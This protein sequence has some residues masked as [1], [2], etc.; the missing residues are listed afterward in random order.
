MKKDHTERKVLGL[1]A[2]WLGVAAAVSGSI[3]LAACDIDQTEEGEMP[4]V[5][6]EGGKLPEYEVHTPD[7]DVD[8]EEKTIKVPDV[9]IDIPEEEENEPPAKEEPPLPDEGAN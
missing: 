2:R 9:D 7:V 8:M 5:D 6:V 4:D 1:P 3:A